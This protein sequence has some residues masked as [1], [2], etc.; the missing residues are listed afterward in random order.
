MF[1]SP[2]EHCPVCG[3]MVTLAQAVTEC[4]SKHACA[5]DQVCPLRKY[6]SGLDGSLDPQMKPSSGD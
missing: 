3:E 6:F 1:D 2:M 4:Q 5:K